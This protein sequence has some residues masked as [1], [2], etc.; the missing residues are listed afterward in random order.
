MI[1]AKSNGIKVKGHVGKWY[2]IDN[3]YYNGKRVFLL[4][5]ETYGDAAACV[6]VDENGDL[7]LEDVWNGFDDLYE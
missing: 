7:I 4:E 1:T 6:I 3:S 5:H 2:V